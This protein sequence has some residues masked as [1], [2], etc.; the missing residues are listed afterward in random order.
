MKRCFTP[1]ALP[2]FSS[3]LVAPSAFNN[4]KLQS[5]PARP[6]CGSFSAAGKESGRERDEKMLHPCC[7]PGFLAWWRHLLSMAS[8]SIK[9]SNNFQIFQWILI[10]RSL[11]KSFSHFQS[12]LK[13]G[14]PVSV[15]GYFLFY[16]LV[17]VN[18]LWFVRIQVQRIFIKHS[19]RFHS[20]K[21]FI[22]VQQ[23]FKEFLSIKSSFPQLD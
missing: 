14:L 9:A 22:K 11:S 21:V 23:C 8:N 16:V 17:M 19:G 13:N 3:S 7:S 20:I 1:V 10:K 12:N 4:L 2:D 5:R 6:A 18:S 15:L